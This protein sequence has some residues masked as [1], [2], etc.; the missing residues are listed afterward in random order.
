MK[1][2]QNLTKKAGLIS[3]AIITGVIAGLSIEEIKAAELFNYSDL[4]TG[5]NIR[6]ELIDLNVNPESAVNSF[7]TFEL[8]CGE[9]K[10]GGEDAKDGKKDKK[11]G[12]SEKKV[13]EKGAVKDAKSEDK[14]AESKCG[15]GKCGE[16]KKDAEAKEDKTTESKCGEGKCG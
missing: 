5:A 9:G 3:G 13:D 16:E 7:N 8:K 1:R 12:K 6:S 11:D 10:C 14:T 4:G 2:K 15:E